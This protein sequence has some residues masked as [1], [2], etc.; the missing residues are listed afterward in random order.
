MFGPTKITLFS[1]LTKTHCVHFCC[2]CGIHPD[3]KFFINQ[4]TNLCIWQCLFFRHHIWQKKFFPPHIL[5]LQTRCN[6]SLNIF[7]VLSTL[8]GADGISLLK[9]HQA[10][11]RPKINY[12]C[13]TNGSAGTFY[14]KML[15]TVHHSTLQICSVAF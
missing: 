4:L 11:L 7:K 10:S 8:W 6:K 15:N 2:V 14:L 1:H 9:I 3:S 5:N 13:Q 12:G